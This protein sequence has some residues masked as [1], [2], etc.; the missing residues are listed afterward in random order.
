[1][2]RIPDGGSTSST[3]KTGS[4]SATTAPARTRK[5]Q[6]KAAPASK[7]PGGN[8]RASQQKTHGEM[9]RNK[10]QQAPKQVNDA[11][12]K[13][14][15]L[16]ES[17]NQIRANALVAKQNKA[18]KGLDAIQQEMSTLQTDLK[19]AARTMAKNPDDPGARRMLDQLVD[20][21]S[22]LIDRIKS[23]ESTIEDLSGKISG[24]E[25]QAGSLKG[26]RD[27]ID[28]F[29]PN[30]LEKLNTLK[31]G[32]GAL[33]VGMDIVGKLGEFQK[34]DPQNW[35]KNVAK[36]VTSSLSGLA[37]IKIKGQGMGARASAAEAATALVKL[38]LEAAGLKDT[39]LYQT[40]DLASQAFPGD[41]VSKGMEQLVEVG[42]ASWES[43]STGKTDRWMDLNDRNLKGQNGAV[44]QGAAIL[45]D[46]TFN[47][48]KGVPTSGDGVY[49]KDTFEPMMTPNPTPQ[50]AD[51][52]LGRAPNEKTAML[53]Q[54]QG[55]STPDQDVA[56][57]R[58][59]LLTAKGVDLVETLEGLKKKELVASLRPFKD[60]T[61][62]EVD[63]LAETL[64]RL[65]GELRNTKS[66]SVRERLTQQTMDLL[67]EAGKQDREESLRSLEQARL[68]GQMNDLPAGVRA[69]VEVGYLLAKT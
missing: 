53:R 25:A 32:A 61:G 18:Y 48:G 2:G 9:M 50:L 42:Y 60:G 30:A 62:K 57:M 16:A 54:N 38:G 35:E 68:R 28:N 6:A 46:L 7:D 44:V 22:N 20:R 12:D 63:P 8:V 67:R 21:R 37:D 36:A 55:A 17:A 52:R 66:D 39:K 24:T 14:T 10:V 13:G 34:Q 40:A 69:G 19:K 5:P 23:A 4:V 3:I 26:T 1:M 45:A 15:Q 31:G 49:F 59:I 65:V 33:L 58:S 64:N 27:S 29:K 47:G 41:V 11:A 43:I 51:G 56:N